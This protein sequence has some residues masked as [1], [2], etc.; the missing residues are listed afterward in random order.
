MA[1]GRVR[2]GSGCSP[3]ALG[4]A[5]W[6]SSP[7]STASARVDY[8]GTAELRE[9]WWAALGRS[10]GRRGCTRDS[11]GGSACRGRHSG[12]RAVYRTFQLVGLPH[13]GMEE[14]TS[15]RSHLSLR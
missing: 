6:A 15:P 5:Q 13:E 9:R 11:R 2:A 10:R 8:A 3:A 12:I 4:L 1:K 14:R 7:R